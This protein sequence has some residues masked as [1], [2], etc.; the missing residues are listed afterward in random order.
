[1]SWETVNSR[2]II[3]SF[4]TK[5]DIKPNIIQVYAP[6]SNTEEVIKDE[7]LQHNAGNP[8]PP[9]KQTYNNSNQ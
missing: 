7:T 2:I 5:K 1:M 9:R 8:G 6:R 4:S 3:P